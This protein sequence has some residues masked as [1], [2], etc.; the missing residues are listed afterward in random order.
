[1]IRVDEN[2]VAV[3][4]PRGRELLYLPCM[5]DIG[6]PV[7]HI[8]YEPFPEVAPAEPTPVEEPEREAVPA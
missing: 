4:T 6:E 5:G 1:M 7:R 8:E 2:T 3:Q